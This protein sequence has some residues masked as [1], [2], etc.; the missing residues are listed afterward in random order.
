M[1][2][3]ET[4]GAG[5]DGA[6]RFASLATRLRDLDDRTSISDLVDR[7]FLALDQGRFD[8]EYARRV[9]T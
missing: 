1:T 8:Q 2:G 5:T 6:D 9:F 4:N 7:Y 3:T